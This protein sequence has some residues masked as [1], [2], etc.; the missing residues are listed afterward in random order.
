[1]LCKWENKKI[2][3]IFS[4]NP[5]FTEGGIDLFSVEAHCTTFDKIKIQS[6]YFKYKLKII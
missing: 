2:A 5:I 6:S 3:G 1:M 4:K